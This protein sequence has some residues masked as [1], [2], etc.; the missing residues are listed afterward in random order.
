MKLKPINIIVLPP[1]VHK[2]LIFNV[3]RV[4]CFYITDVYLKDTKY[5]IHPS[6][7]IVRFIKF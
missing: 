2:P 1:Q 7:S 4:F 3:L 6:G 5:R